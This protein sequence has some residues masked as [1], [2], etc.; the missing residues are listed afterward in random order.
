M[1]SPISR[2]ELRDQATAFAREMASFLEQQ[3]TE[4]RSP[5]AVFR[6]PRDTETL[7]LLE[8]QYARFVARRRPIQILL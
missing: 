7:I 2:Q 6:S 3:N 5:N 8:T 4:S 1:M